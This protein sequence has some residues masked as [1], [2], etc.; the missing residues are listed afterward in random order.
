MLAGFSLF[1]VAGAFLKDAGDSDIDRLEHPDRPIPAGQFTRAGILK[2]GYGL[3]VFALLA[4]TAAHV[5]AVAEHG[6]KGIAWLVA[7][8]LLAL[9]IM[10]FDVNR[11]F[12]SLLLSLCRVMIII[13]G[14]YLLTAVLPP[15]VV[16]G[17]ALSL[18]YL[19][20]IAFIVK[21]E[22]VAWIAQSLPV[23]LLAVPIVFGLLHVSTSAWIL[24]PIFLLCALICL[25]VYLVRRG[26]PPDVPRATKLLV[27]G[28]CLLDAI[29][30]APYAATSWVLVATGLFLV[31]LV[32]QRRIRIS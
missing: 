7:S 15:P 24:L 20:G 22:G 8:L 13:T 27:A 17:A 28:I 4:L 5:L 9:L 1:Y 12:R 31:T 14:S 23:L 11:G 26:R 25:A 32:L 21:Q 19:L 2:S 30:I 10:G 29:L 6:S 16:V 18:S 3:I